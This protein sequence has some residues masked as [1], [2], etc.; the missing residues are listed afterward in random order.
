MAEK[1]RGCDSSGLTGS[2]P[3]GKRRRPLWLRMLKWL[4]VTAAV[5]VG[6]FVAV[7]SLIVWILTPDRLT[8]LVERQASKYLLADVSL[9]RVELT[10]WKSFPKMTVDVDSDGGGYS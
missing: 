10:F 4:G 3:R 1:E 7:C 8:P 9:G 6:L 2:D 5:V